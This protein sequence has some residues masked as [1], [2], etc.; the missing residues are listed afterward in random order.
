MRKTLFTSALI[1]SLLFTIT[2]PAKTPVEKHGQLSVE[3]NTVVGADGEPAQLRGMSFFWSQWAG[4]YWNSDVV[5]WLADDWKATLVR[6]AMGVETINS[7]DPAYLDNKEQHMSLVKTIVDAAIENGIYVVIDWHDHN[8]NS[9]E[10]EAIQFFEEMAREYGDQPNVIYEIF[11]EPT[12]ISWSDDVKPYSENVIDAI[13]AIDPDNLIVVGTPK[14]CQD[15]H[16]AAADPI[17]K[18]NIV[19]SLH[20]YAASHQDSL[21]ELAQE[22]LDLGA[23][24]LVSEFGTCEYTGDGYVDEA[25]TEEWFDFMDENHISW[26]NWSINDKA[27]SASALNGGAS[28]SGN[29]S[30]SDLTQSGQFIRSKLREYSKPTA[31]DS[32]GITIKRTG[33]GTIDLSPEGPEFQYNSE[34]TVTATPE[35]GWTFLGWSGDLSGVEN[36]AQITMDAEKSIVANFSQQGSN[37]ANLVNNGD[38]ENGDTDWNFMASGAQAEGSVTDGEYVTD[39]SSAGSEDWNVQFTQNV[40]LEQDKIYRI[41]FK[42]RA[43][44]PRSIEINVGMD[45][46][47][48]TS[49]M[50]ATQVQLSTEMDTHMQTFTM[51]SPS[52]ADAR[53]EFNSGSE[54]GTWYL[55]DVVLEEIDVITGTVQNSPVISPWSVNVKNSKILLQFPRTGMVNISLYDVRGRNVA[56]LHDGRIKAGAVEFSTKDLPAG[57]YIL[58]IRDFSAGRTMR[59]K[60][61]LLR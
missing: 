53:V 11:N 1:V 61:A 4:K 48:Y 20:Y 35:E 21:R 49:Y 15:V 8:A 29:W 50:G 36:P 9:H 13:R 12:D 43:Q 5:D 6:A 34:V 17:N 58:Q 3:G 33:E 18:E 47:D 23:P 45:G 32:F 52:D 22:A 7:E 60:I 56:C 10:N 44:S 39:I 30:E 27:E 24:L 14:W 55:D 25:E 37:S 31:S 40:S 38:F 16:I 41:S 28:E 54:S 42:A 51:N 46:D 57:N 59:K 19:Y 26:A 2:T